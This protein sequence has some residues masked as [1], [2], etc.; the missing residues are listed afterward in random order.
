MKKIFIFMLICL[1]IIGCT[2]SN[3]NTNT[4]QDTWS[5]PTKQVINTATWADTIETNA[6]T[7][8]EKKSTASA[9]KEAA[10]AKAMAKIE[11]EKKLSEEET[12]TASEE[13]NTETISWNDRFI[14][15]YPY[16]CDLLG[17]TQYYYPEKD[18]EYSRNEIA[19]TISHMV[20]RDGLFYTWM[21]MNGRII[22]G[23]YSKDTGT[24][25]EEEMKEN[26]SDEM[27]TFADNMI[28][29][30]KDTCTKW[31]LDESIFEIP[32]SVNFIDLDAME[33]IMGDTNDT[34]PTE[35]E[36]KMIIEWLKNLQNNK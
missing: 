7:E 16:E 22:T 2:K 21:E 24:Y 11:K 10:L 26:L 34:L 6:D 8:K 25:S 17:G 23:S 19:G 4:I 9:A 13:N 32:T 31:N 28:Q 5:T 1:S 18:M 35:E 15:S 3:E 12:K 36:Q 33:S 20:R 30:A 27:N 14:F 29:V